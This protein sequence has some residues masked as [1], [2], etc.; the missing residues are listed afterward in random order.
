MKWE[1]VYLPVSPSQQELSAPLHTNDAYTSTSRPSEQ[2][3]H[4]VAFAYGPYWWTRIAGHMCDT[5]RAFA[6]WYFRLADLIA[7]SG[8]IQRTSTGRLQSGVLAELER[9]V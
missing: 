8:C 3:S 2:L 1:H 9:E 4:E 7:N 5:C 6:R